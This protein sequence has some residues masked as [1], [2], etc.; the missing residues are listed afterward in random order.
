[1]KEILFRKLHQYVKDNNPELLL[2]LEEEHKVTAWLSDKLKSIETILAAHEG[3]PEYIIEEVCMKELTNGLR[4]SKFNYISNI[5]EEE[6][7]NEY[8]Q[9]LDAGILQFEIINLIRECQPVFEAIGFTEENEDGDDL[10][11]V[12]AGTISE[13][14]EKRE[15]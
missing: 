10:K 13:Y 7:E 6:F 15:A 8:R 2:Q 14:L 11:N 1:M 9:F 4:P 3:P 12:V 5:L